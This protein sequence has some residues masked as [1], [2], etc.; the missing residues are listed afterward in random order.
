M[1][2]AEPAKESKEGIWLDWGRD[3][4]AG[5][6]WSDVPKA[7][8]RRLFM[9]WM[10]NWAYANLVPTENWRSAMTVARSLSL[11]N[12]AAGLRL[13]SQPVNELQAIYGA[14]HNLQA[15][16]VSGVLN[17][18]E[19]LSATPA[20]FALNLN[21]VTAGADSDFMVELS[22]SMGQKAVVGYDAAR[23]EYFINRTA[24]GAHTFSDDFGG[25]HWAP[26]IATGSTHHLQLLVDVASVE[27]FADG[28]K[29][30]MTDVLFPDEPFT[31]LT[32][33]TSGGQVQLKSGEL[34]ELKSIWSAAN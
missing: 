19:T 1:F 25:I 12:T 10:S 33:Q 6:T 20:T 14:T 23:N 16:P 29:T 11:E 17:I 4:Y 8:G 3:N 2:A 27:F 15:Q 34:I 28:G 26:R 5:V 21:L 24:A 7:D 13:T 9:G 32:L 30:V 18:S 22:N 31:F